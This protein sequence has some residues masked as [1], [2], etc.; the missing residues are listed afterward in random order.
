MSN[1]IALGQAMYQKSVT[2]FLH[3]TP[4]IT[5]LGDEEQ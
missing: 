5:D 4:K 3:P 1:F 2:I